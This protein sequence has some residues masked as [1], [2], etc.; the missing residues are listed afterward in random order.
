MNVKRRANS[1]FFST[2]R[3]MGLCVQFVIFFLGVNFSP[4][5]QATPAPPTAPVPLTLNQAIQRMLDSNLNI[6]SLLLGLESSQISYDVAWNT[7]FMPT[8]TLASTNT[9]AY[10]IGSVPLA[11]GRFNGATALGYPTSTLS[12]ALGSYTLFNFFKDRATYDIAK[13]DYD[14]ANTRYQEAIRSAKFQLITSYFTTKV[15]QEKLDSAARSMTISQAIS[16]L[17]DSRKKLGKATEDEQNSAAVD[18]LNAK[19]EYTSQKTNW[20]QAVIAL[21]TTLNTTPETEYKLTTEP[22]FVPVHLDEKAFFYYFKTQSPSIRD[23]E[24][25]LI[26]AEMG[27][28]IAEKNRLP[29]PTLSFS[30]ITINYANAYNGGTSPTYVSSTDSTNGLIEI[31]ATVSLSIPIFGPQGFFNQKQFDSAYIQRE[32]SEISQRNAMMTGELT[33]RQQISSI[34]SIESQIKTLRETITKNSKILDNIFKKSANSS[35]DRLQLRDAL[36]QARQSELS[37][38]DTLLSHINAKNTLA[39][40]IGLDRL[41]GDQI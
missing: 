4:L 31:A 29:L 10:A 30:G 41:P 13:L 34:T 37:Y 17:L 33:I 19:V 25:G 24:L 7:F 3:S 38:Y 9:S 8:F 39:G 14:R 23:Q 32:N 36:L 18:L 40:F 11:P 27:L 1:L 6:K 15:A 22:P 5:T 16:E 26:K 28:A 20:E 21:N 35:T 12:L 2:P